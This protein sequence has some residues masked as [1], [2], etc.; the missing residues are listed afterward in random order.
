MID[1][2]PA[3]GNTIEEMREN[4]EKTELSRKGTSKLVWINED[5]SILMNF[6]AQ[7][8]LRQEP[9]GIDIGDTSEFYES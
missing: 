8:E 9:L 3:V 5:D 4:F 2:E 6:R 1:Y 7:L